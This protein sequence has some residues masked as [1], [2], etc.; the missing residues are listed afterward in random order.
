MKA[1]IETN[2][3][4]IKPNA[5]QPRKKKILVADD[6]TALGQMMRRLLADEGYSVQVA[7]SGMEAL[8]MAKAV[9]FDLVLLDLTMPDQDGWETFEQLSTQHPVLPVIVITARP[10]QLFSAMA[11][12]AGALLEK[13]LDFEKLFATLR[14]LLDEP[15]GYRLARLLGRST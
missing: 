9:R 4:D 7:A 8:E 10:N 6:D 15:E 14:R 2:Q 11:A 1:T 3:R 13:P 12:G 5:V